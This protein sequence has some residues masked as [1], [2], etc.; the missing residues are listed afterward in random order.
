MLL[1]PEGMIGL[2]HL[3]GVP[4]QERQLPHL[5]CTCLEGIPQTR[6]LRVEVL[7]EEGNACVDALD[8]FNRTPADFARKA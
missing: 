7:V 6:D 3:P 1:T 2:D 8:R 4:I 5:G